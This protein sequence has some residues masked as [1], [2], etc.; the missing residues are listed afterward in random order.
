MWECVIDNHEDFNEPMELRYTDMDQV[1]PSMLGVS[2]ILWQNLNRIREIEKEIEAIRFLQ[3]GEQWA[4]EDGMYIDAENG[5]N[6]IQLQSEKCGLE[7]GNLRLR[8]NLDTLLLEW[9]RLAGT[10]SAQFDKYKAVV[11]KSLE[12]IARVRLIYAWDENL[13]FDENDALYSH[14]VWEIHSLI[15]FFWFE[16]RQHSIYAFEGNA[17]FESIYTQIEWMTFEDISK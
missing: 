14:F 13:N 16:D 12:G 5:L 8:E 15:Y 7:A 11:L 2:D 1:S 6:W 10:S 17:N 9:Q 4:N 3:F